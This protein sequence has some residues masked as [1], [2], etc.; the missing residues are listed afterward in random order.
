MATP[1]TFTISPGAA[2]L[3]NAE[4]AAAASC[5]ESNVYVTFRTTRPSR[6]IPNSLDF[7]SRVGPDSLCFCGH[8]YKAHLKSKKSLGRT[9]CPECAASNRVCH[10][11]QFMFTRPEEVGDTHLPRRRGFNVHTWKAKCKCGHP[12]DSH[13][14]RSTSCV[15]CSCAAFSSN[16]LCGQCD[17]H[18]EDH[19]TVWETGEERRSKGLVVGDAFVPLA[20]TGLQEDVFGRADELRPTPAPGSTLEERFERG[21]IDA[22]QYRT[23]LKDEGAGMAGGGGGGGVGMRVQEGMVSKG[24]LAPAQKGG[25]K[26]RT[27]AFMHETSGGSAKGEVANRW[28]KVEK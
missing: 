5:I 11:F 17:A 27:I 13:A 19:E 26:D 10:N 2:A 20:G 15:E 16:F 3:L 12:H 25:K 1:P 24:R 9:K 4:R 22:A 14:T 28:G 6:S 23:L 18:W 7:C 21:E 8:P